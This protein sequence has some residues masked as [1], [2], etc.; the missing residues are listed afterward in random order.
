[1][2]IRIIVAFKEH[3]WHFYLQNILNQDEQNEINLYKIDQLAAIHWSLMTWPKISLITI[4][5][6]FWYTRFLK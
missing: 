5:Y 1:M 4:Q 2:D 3:Y 6:Y